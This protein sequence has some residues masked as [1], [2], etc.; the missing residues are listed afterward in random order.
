MAF[1]IPSSTLFPTSALCKI[2]PPKEGTKVQE[3][4]TIVESTGSISSSIVMHPKTCLAVTSSG[5]LAEPATIIVSGLKL[6]SA[7]FAFLASTSSD[8]FTRNSELSIL[9]S[10]FFPFCLSMISPLLGGWHILTFQFC[11]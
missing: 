3:V 8:F 1:S 2:F 6:C 9:T 4:S 7:A 10:T 5:N 11:F